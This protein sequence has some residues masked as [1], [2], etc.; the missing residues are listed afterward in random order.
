MFAL[1]RCAVCVCERCVQCVGVWCVC[2]CVVRVLLGVWLCVVGVRRCVWS[3]VVVVC[4]THSQ[5]HGFH[6]HTY[7]HV[8]VT[9][10]AHFLM[11][12][13][14]QSRTLTFHDVCFSKPLTFQNGFM[15]FLLVAVSSSFL[16]FRKK[17]WSLK[18]RKCLKQLREEKNM[19]PLWK[20]QGFEKQTSWKVSVLDFV[21]HDKMSKKSDADMYMYILMKM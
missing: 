4:R 7:V 21:I 3:C 19:K 18:S 11:K 14:T 12:R 5:Y 10:F 2:W 16:Y 8:G 13:K 15:F 1:T 6:I 20:V 9:L 17:K